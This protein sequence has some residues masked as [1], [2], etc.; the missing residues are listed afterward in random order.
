MKWRSLRFLVNWLESPKYWSLSYLKGVWCVSVFWWKWFQVLFRYQCQ[1]LR[2]RSHFLKIRIGGNFFRYQFTFKIKA[3]F[4][5]IGDSFQYIS[6]VFRYGWGFETKVAL[7]S[8]LVTLF[9]FRLIDFSKT[10]I[11]AAFQ[12]LV[13]LFKR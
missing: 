1:F 13:V 6:S 8:I 4:W 9:F 7:F 3:I 2:E 12:Y 10:K 11:V 5:D